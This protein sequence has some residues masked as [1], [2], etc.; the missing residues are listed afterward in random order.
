MTERR[1]DV[2]DSQ[3]EGAYVI[4]VDGHRAGRAE[5]VIREGRRVF[6]HTEIENDFSGMG[7]GTRLVRHA[8]EDVRAE[9]GLMVPICPFFATYITRHPE[10]E[11]LVDRALTDRLEARRRQR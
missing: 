9:G 5:Y 2:R 6:T 10:Y 11:D 8:L 4:E 7:L 1:V 3:E